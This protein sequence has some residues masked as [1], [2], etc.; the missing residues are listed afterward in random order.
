MKT[1]HRNILIPHSR[2]HS[3]A[4][5]QMPVNTE[6]YKDKSLNVLF[7][8]F[9]NTT[10]SYTRSF[11]L[12]PGTAFPRQ[13]HINGDIALKP[14]INHMH[15]AIFS[16]IVMLRKNA[17]RTVA[18]LLLCTFTYV[19]SSAEQPL[20]IFAAAS[21]KNVLDDVAQT[22]ENSINTKITI[23]YAGS[24]TLARQIQLGA[25]ADIFVSANSDWIQVLDNENLIQTSSTI[26][27]ASNRLVLIGLHDQNR[28]SPQWQD[29]PSILKVNDRFVLAL[30]QS[31]PA[32]IYGRLALER[33]NLWK[34]LQ[35]FVIETEN[36]RAAMRLVVLGEAEMGIVYATDAMTDPRIRI[37]R[38]FPEDSH[39]EIKYT[40]A[41]T[42]HSQNDKAL[43]FLKWL[44]DQEAQQTFRK[45]GFLPRRQR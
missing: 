20:I 21:L 37:L 42:A 10:F 16:L 40:A 38:E 31:V 6:S 33:L 36:V 17:F 22:F 18:G 13:L 1:C 5:L 7:S 24:S 25:P 39:P 14:N 27:L 30:T 44:I 41:M 29:L 45:H 23:S 12:S 3:D 34:S 11:A 8:I 9:Y 2:P 43:A 19:A 28:D 15:D 4:Q 35:P 26:N 32:G